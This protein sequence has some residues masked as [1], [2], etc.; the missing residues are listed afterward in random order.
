MDRLLTLFVFA[1]IIQRI[2]PK[3]ELEIPVLMYHSV[4]NDLE[5]NLHPY[6]QTVTSPKV[7]EQH[8][9]ALKDWGFEVL[10]L[11][12]A[13]TLLQTGSLELNRD[14]KIRNTSARYVVI[15]FDDGFRD[16]YTN[17]FPIL[18]KYGY[19][20][21]VF[22]TTDYIGKNFVTG[23]ECLQ[24][25]EIKELHERGIE[26]GSHTMSHPLLRNL[27]PDQIVKE[28]SG[29]RLYIQTL[30][31]NQVDLFSYPYGFPEEN[32]A[33][34]DQLHNILLK[35][36]YVAGVTTVIGRA[37]ANDLPFFLKRLP[38]NDLDDLS[39]FRAKLIG[40]YDWLHSAQWIFKK[41]R[42][43]VGS[44]KQPRQHQTLDTF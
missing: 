29:S 16:F 17:A 20:A 41:F 19:K 1:P 24:E 3:R 10:L 15:T 25:N 44:K 27:Q 6:F 11:S 8:M 5:K 39:F 12:E 40:A 28:V 32:I 14:H 38:I 36:G 23:K 43:L 42:S 22:L 13:V 26:F 7:F 4:G 9:R 30:L 34:T 18:E 33:F 21:T 31:N 2:F 37:K 35:E